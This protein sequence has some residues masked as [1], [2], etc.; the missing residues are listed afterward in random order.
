MNRCYI[1]TD[2]SSNGTKLNDKKMEPGVPTKAKPGARLAL[3][4]GDNVFV[5]Q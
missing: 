1:V 5:L 2:Y 3:G 4:K